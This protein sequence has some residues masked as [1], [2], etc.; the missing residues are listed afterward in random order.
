MDSPGT[1]LVTKLVWNFGSWRTI[2]LFVRDDLSHFGGAGDWDHINEHYVASRTGQRY[3]DTQFMKVDNVAM[4]VGQYCDGAKSATVNFRAKDADLQKSVIIKR[5]FANEDQF[6]KAARPTPIQFFYVARTP[7]HEALPKA[8]YLGP[9]RVNGRECQSFLFKNVHYTVGTQ[10]QVYYLDATSG[11]PLKVVSYSDEASRT[12]ETPLWT[13]TCGKLE[14]T[15]GHE[16]PAISTS[17]SYGPD[18]KTVTGTHTYT[19]ESIKFDQEYA[20]TTFWPVIQPGVPVLDSIA[21]KQYETPGVKLPETKS[22]T[23]EPPLVATQPRDWSSTFSFMALC[24][25]L[26][27]LIAG[28]VLWWRRR[29]GR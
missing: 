17:N 14:T 19:V 25:G 18:G 8:I 10:D 3:S 22:A 27:I 21:K 20:A 9:D 12:K 5:D 16:I 1:S 13:W 6:G 11:T 7:L 2:E 23:A 26:G 4:R 15:Q 28:G 29:Q 24:L